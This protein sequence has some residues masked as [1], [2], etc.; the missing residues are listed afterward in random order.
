MS[1]IVNIDTSKGNS[2]FQEIPSGFFNNLKRLGKIFGVTWRHVI[3]M[4]REAKENRLSKEALRGHTLSWGLRM[5]ELL[6][7]SVKVVGEPA[8]DEPMLFLGNH[9]SYIDI[10]LLMAYAPVV[11]VAKKQVGYWPIFGDACRAVGV[12]LVDRDSKKS[13]EVTGELVAQAITTGKQSVAVFPSGTTCINEKKPW[14]WGAFRIA[15]THGITV[16]P[17]RLTY[18]PMR[19]AAYI[20]DDAFV[21]HL[22]H[23]LNEPR[24]RVKLE[25]HPPVKITDAEADCEKWYRWS[26]EL[27]LPTL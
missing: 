5:L 7:V 1:H 3:E 12:V 16:Q 23:L 8:T 26:R 20:D 11:F 15:Q 6:H 25:F 4:N 22:W 17:F 19:T 2:Q 18:L 27:D 9:I 21:P 10:P 14:R 24:I 13:R